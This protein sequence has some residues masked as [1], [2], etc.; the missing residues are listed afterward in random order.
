LVSASDTSRFDERL[1]FH[2]L[3]N[4]SLLAHFQFTQSMTITK[5]RRRR[6][7]NYGTFPAVM[8]ELVEDYGVGEMRVSFGKGRWNQEGWG[9]AP[10]DL[11][12]TGFQLHAWLSNDS[13]GVDEK[14]EQLTGALSGIFCGSISLVAG[15]KTAEPRLSF[16]SPAIDPAHY[17]LRFGILPRETVCT[18]NLTPWI[19]LLPCMSNGGLASLINPLRVYDSRFNLMDLSLRQVAIGSEDEVR[20]EVVQNLVLVYDLERWTRSPDWSLASVFDR[21]VAALCP[22]C[23]EPRVR[24][25]YEPR[26]GE[27]AERHTDYEVLSKRDG[28]RLVEYRGA[29][30]VEADIGVRYRGKDSPPGTLREADVVIERF[31]TGVGQESGSLFV[32]IRNVNEDGEALPVKLLEVLPWYLRIYMHTL[33]AELNDAPFD[34]FKRLLFS[35]AVD[36]QK[37]AQIE[38]ELVLP[39][40]STLTIEIDFDMSLLR[41][42]EYPLDPARGV[43]LKY[44]N[45]FNLKTHLL[46]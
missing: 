19:K 18:E 43:D 25:S 41:Y 21:E 35:P 12:S 15:P 17:S 28:V 2:S 39:A 33:R 29:P 40:N 8:A 1:T 27:L 22:A 37:P 13:G 44:A 6:L 11:A 16:S 45:M 20:V 36:R 31:I 5:G 32:R 42:T 10:V 30:I 3:D 34:D 24:L 7:V 14:W 46:D 38:Y 26:L 23:K 4:G 9:V